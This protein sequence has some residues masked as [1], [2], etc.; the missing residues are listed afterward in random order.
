MKLYFMSQ[1]PEDCVITDCNALNMF[2]GYDPAIRLKGDSESQ[3]DRSLRQCIK[4]CIRRQNLQSTSGS[5]ESPPTDKYASGDSRERSLSRGRLS[6]HPGFLRRKGSHS[7]RSR[8]R[9]SDL[10][11]GEIHSERSYSERTGKLDD[12]Q[13]QDSS[14]LRGTGQE[15]NVLIFDGVA[16]QFILTDDTL[17]TM[18]LTLCSLCS[19]SIGSN[20]SPHQRKFVVR[21]IREFAMQGKL[22]NVVSIVAQ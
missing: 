8:N 18:F 16:L 15:K 7:P 19:V 10:G 11:S 22:G 5:A 13:P 2:A 3:V 14:E 6:S 12:K 4:E 17:K 9:R 21:A 1:E 20:V